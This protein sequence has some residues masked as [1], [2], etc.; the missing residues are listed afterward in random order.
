M[1]D[2]SARKLKIDNNHKEQ[3]IQD[4]LTVSGYAD[5]AYKAATKEKQKQR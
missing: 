1:M 5:A 2:M 4:Y 3:F